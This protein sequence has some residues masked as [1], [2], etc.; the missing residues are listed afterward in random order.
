MSTTVVTPKA[1]MAFPELLEPKD[2]L[3]GRTIYSMTLLFPKGTDLSELKAAAEEAALK[4]WPK[5]DAWKGLKLQFPFSDGN[6]KGKTDAE[7]NF[8][9]YKGYDDTTVLNVKRQ[10]KNGPPVVV[11]ANPH[12]SVTDPAEVYGGRW[13]RAQLNAFAYEHAGNRG[14]SFGLNMVQLLEHDEP[15]GAVNNPASIFG[16]EHSTGAGNPDDF[17]S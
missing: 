4:K 9:V 14:V 12:L 16:D 7:G 1:R 3:S 6:T 15:L 8:R 13:C 2:D 11:Q 10:A 5:K 17:M